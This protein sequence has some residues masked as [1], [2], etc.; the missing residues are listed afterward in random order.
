MKKLISLA[1]ALMLLMGTAAAPAA[2]AAATV[3]KVGVLSMLNLDAAR[4]KDILTARQILIQMALAQGSNKP[5]PAIEVTYYDSLQEMQLA[6]SAGQIDRMEIYETTARYLCANTDELTYMGHEDID[7]TSAAG[8]I[9]MTGI[10]VND[11]AFMMMEDRGALRD[12]F[13]TAIAAIKED[14]TMD[15]LT[16]EYIEGV[17]AGKEMAAIDIPAIDGAETIRVAITGSLPPMDYVAADGTPA[18]FNTALLAEISKRTG[19]N[20]EPVQVDSMGRAAAL[21]SGTVDVVFWMRTSESARQRAEMSD[22]EAEAEG[23]SRA[24]GLGRDQIATIAKAVSLI[25]NEEYMKAD[26]P[27][28]TI[29][30]DPYFTDTLVVVEMKQ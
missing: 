27:E 10:Q 30:T 1:L 20:I 6:L 25:D 26:M 9:L 7:R 5:L 13:N 29:I 22:E 3:K 17:I 8:V 18:G 14:G 15:R 23:L 12:E 19:K 4:M 21:A 16:A 11:F 2:S 28:R 24:A